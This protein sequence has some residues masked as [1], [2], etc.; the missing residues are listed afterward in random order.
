MDPNKT[1]EFIRE[2]IRTSKTDET[3]FYEESGWMFELVENLDEWLTN[4]GFLPK[5]WAKT[6][7]FV[8]YSGEHLVIE[9]EFEDGYDGTRRYTVWCESVPWNDEED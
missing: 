5:E 7:R 3:V 1:L 4:G 6:E 9:T 8:N 2:L